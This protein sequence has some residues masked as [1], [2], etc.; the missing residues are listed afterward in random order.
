[1]DFN[2]TNISS[3]LHF[4]AELLS[5]D[6]PC[7][8]W[9]Y[10]AEG[11]LLD[12]TC[13]ELLLDKIFRSN[14]C[15]DY[16]LSHAA[17]TDAPL[18][19]SGSLGMIWAAAFELEEG[20]LY[21]IHV[22]GPAFS[23]TV[24][25]EEI[26]RDLANKTGYRM[27]RK[28][29]TVMEQ[30]PVINTVRFISYIHMMQYCITGEQIYTSDIVMQREKKIQREK[31]PEENGI[32]ADRI[33]VHMAEQSLLSMIR[34]GDMNYKSVLQNSGR[35]FT[36]KQKLSANPLQHIKLGQVQF[37]ALCCNAALEGGLSAETAYNRKDAY[38]QGIEQAGSI[39]EIME[40]SNTMY[41]DYITLVHR[42]HTASPYSK[43]IQSSVDYI[44][45]HLSENLSV[46][47]IAH[48]VGYSDYYLS[49]LFKK[50]TGLSIDEYARNVK[51]ERAKEM[52]AFSRDSIH[53]IAEALGF[54]G[55][56]YFSVIF[57]RITG[58]SPAAYRK[59]YQRL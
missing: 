6:A 47:S 19:M 48:R 37:A 7:H 51:I 38:I 44:E 56:N 3:R 1:M 45:N 42:Q 17:K 15:F 53:D 25:G 58:M 39:S 18:L 54:N 4:F 20:E 16:M 34:N 50:E 21:Q 40:I 32:Y 10:S 2:S 30:V 59:Q 5:C 11:I 46:A 33:Q 9:T 22:L 23:Q 27:K 26:E 24:A 8:L 55:R 31:D 49:R 28:I 52:L 13:R 43:A 36:G 29:L 41:V 57:R 12:S 35:F 14:G